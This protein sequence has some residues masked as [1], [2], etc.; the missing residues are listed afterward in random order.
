MAYLLPILTLL[1]L[2]NP[3]AAEQRIDVG[4][5]SKSDIS[6]WKQKSFVGE[7]RYELVER[8]SPSALKATSDG[9]ASA[10]YFPIKVDLTKTPVL[11][12]SWQKLQ[13]LDPGDEN[14]KSGD[15]FVARVYVIK[16]G[17]VFFW[18][19]R[20]INYVWSYQH[21]KHEVWD[22]PFAGKN[23]MMLAQRD[24][25]DAEQVWFEERRNIAEDFK[26]LHGI[27]IDHIDGVAIMTDSDNSGKSAQAL[28]GDI[29]F[30]A[31]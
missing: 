28:Y 18:N 29:Y 9:S 10:F 23:A 27:D 30:T 6:G 5:F 31:D 25:T 1:L 3:V 12:W 13:E 20:A 7:T 14:A 26:R 21:R 15:D 22:N 11:N 2:L 8:N 16:K 19:T 17:G 4:Q 24:V